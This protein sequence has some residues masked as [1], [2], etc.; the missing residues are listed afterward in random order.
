M[1]REQ[2]QHHVVLYVAQDNWMRCRLNRDSVQHTLHEQPPL[3]HSID[4]VFSARQFRARKDLCRPASEFPPRR[5]ARSMCGALC[6]TRQKR[7]LYTS[8]SVLREHLRGGQEVRVAPNQHSQTQRRS[9]R[10]ASAASSALVSGFM[11]NESA[12]I[13]AT[14]TARCA[15]AAATCSSWPR[16]S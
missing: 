4:S 8:R 12:G 9:S 15:S 1:R 3:H 7:A 2:R 16:S 6:K 11:K 10:A 13:V 14:S 5:Q